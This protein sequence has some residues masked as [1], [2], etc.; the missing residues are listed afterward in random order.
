[1]SLMVGRGW[2]VERGKKERG[3]RGVG[4]EGGERAHFLS[5]GNVL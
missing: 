2:R 5:F 3:K 4:G 1:M